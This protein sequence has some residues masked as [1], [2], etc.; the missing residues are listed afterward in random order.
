MNISKRT[1][2]MLS[3]AHMYAASFNLN[4]IG[5]EH[6]LLALSDASMTPV[7]EILSRY[8]VGQNVVMGEIVKITGREP[9]AFVEREGD[10]NEIFTHCTNRTKRLLYLAEF[11][12]KKTGKNVVEPEHVLLAILK[13]GQCTAYRILAYHDFD[14]KEAAE[15]LI[16]ILRERAREENADFDDDDDVDEEERDDEENEEEGEEEDPVA[17]FFG[18]ESSTRRSRQTG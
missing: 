16:D 14:A 1:M 8:G 9:G 12:T 6:I 10:P 4:F 17:K 11:L 18:G 13:D 7:D 5:T 2:E 3:R 15:D